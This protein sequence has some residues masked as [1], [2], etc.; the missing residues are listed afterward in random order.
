MCTHTNTH[1]QVCTWTCREG[2]ARTCPSSR[3]KCGGTCPSRRRQGR[4]ASLPPAYHH[5]THTHSFAH[6]LFR[7][8]AEQRRGR[9]RMH[10]WVLTARLREARREEG[11]ACP[12]N[13][14]PPPTA[15][16]AACKLQPPRV[17]CAH[18]LELVHAG[19]AEEQRRVVERHHLSARK[20]PPSCVL[21]SPDHRSS[22]QRR[23]RAKACGECD[24]RGD[25][26]VML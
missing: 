10:F 20:P 8:R 23:K 15:R 4:C 5:V 2:G 21:F 25:D 16:S 24:R 26:E 19:V 6:K 3:R 17:E 11:S 13:T 14:C 9:T 18:R 7:A 22:A 12:R 1:T